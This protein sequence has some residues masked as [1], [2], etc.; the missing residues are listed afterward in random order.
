[1]PGAPPAVDP[2][3]LARQVLASL[4]ISAIEIGL[5]PEAGPDRLGAVGVPIWMWVNDPGPQ[6]LGPLTASDTAGGVT[7]TLDAK[8]ASVDW[9]MGDGTI[10]RC[11]GANAGGT[12]YVDAYDLAESPT[13]GHVYQHQGDPFTITATS[14]WQV[15]W[16]GAGQ[17]GT[18]P[19][20]MVSTTTR[21]I[22]ELQ[23][24]TVE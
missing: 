14:H 19:V 13:C 15:N 20:D 9:D 6:T 10:V 7:V 8:V 1:M 5:V 21:T 17:S 12:Q 23:A 16:V 2:A 18:L 11:D 24:I 4:R 3:V 22:G